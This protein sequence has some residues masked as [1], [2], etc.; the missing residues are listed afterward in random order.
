MLVIGF[1]CL[2]ISCV[3][4][5]LEFLLLNGMWMLVFCLIVVICVV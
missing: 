4:D 5:W 1:F 2:V 3:I